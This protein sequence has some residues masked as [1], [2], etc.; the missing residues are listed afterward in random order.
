MHKSHFFK[1][2]PISIIVV[3]AMILIFYQNCSKDMG[4]NSAISTSTQCSN[5]IQTSNLLKIVKAN[6]LN[7]HD[8]SM[9]NCESRVFNEN[10]SNEVQ[11]HRTCILVEANPLCAP[12]KIHLFNTSSARLIGNTSEIEFQEGGEYNRQEASC[13]YYDTSLKINLLRAEANTTEEALK[14]LLLMC[15]DAQNLKD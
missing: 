10:I 13:N 9:Y 8:H 2:K 7:C 14:K 3:V 5:K 15:Y 1:V 11:T 4:F 6:Q 12:T